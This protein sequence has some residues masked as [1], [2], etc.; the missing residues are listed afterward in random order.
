MATDEKIDVRALHRLCYRATAFRA[1][2]DGGVTDGRTLEGYAAVFD[3][4][5]TIAS[6]E[7]E[8]EEV[9][10]LGAFKETLRRRSP[11]MQFDHGNDKRT[12]SV[13]IGSI[14]DI[15]EDAE[16]LFVR[17]RLFDNDLVEPI[18]QAIAGQAIRG[19]SFKFEVLRDRWLD[20][21]GEELAAGELSELLEDPGD[22]GPVRR[23]ITEVKLYELG[24]VVFPAYEQTSVGVRS[25]SPYRRNAVALRGVIAQFGL[26]ERCIRRHLTMF[27]GEGRVALAREIAATFPEL[28]EV[29][30]EPDPQPPAEE[31]DPDETS[32]GAADGTPGSTTNPD[33]ADSTSGRSAGP[34]MRHPASQ[35]G[36]P[37][38]LLPRLREPRN[39]YTYV[40][41]S[42]L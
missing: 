8:F 28:R 36:R 3:T 6:W 37:A 22:R 16:G 19:M 39:E 42:G 27:D 34:A 14:E 17:S 11:V 23:E 41:G 38:W 15:R 7:G 13:P 20:A 33:A 31:P 21:S 35:A 32:P 25:G 1:T 24:P 2:P 5:T 29:L 30:A 18:R 10:V 12:G 4:P 26:D 40:G 9:V